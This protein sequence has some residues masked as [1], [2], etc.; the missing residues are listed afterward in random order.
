MSSRRLINTRLMKAAVGLEWRY[1]LRPP[2]HFSPLFLTLSL[3]LP[4]P[5]T[6]S[7]SLFPQHGL[8]HWSWLQNASICEQSCWWWCKV[9]WGVSRISIHLKSNPLPSSVIYSV[10]FGTFSGPPLPGGDMEGDGAACIR[11]V[12]GCNGNFFPSSLVFVLE[13]VGRMDGVTPLSLLL[14]FLDQMLCPA[15]CLCCIWSKVVTPLSQYIY[16]HFK[17]SIILRLRQ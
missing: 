16:M 14:C 13:R 6:R 5:L 1:N 2:F 4:H 7:S 15:V 17:T 12:T 9:W 11:C 3:S 10:A 8:C